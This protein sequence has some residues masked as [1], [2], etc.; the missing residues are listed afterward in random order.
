VVETAASKPW[1]VIVKCGPLLTT[2]ES[3]TS[4]TT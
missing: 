1:L 3:R 2:A 4:R